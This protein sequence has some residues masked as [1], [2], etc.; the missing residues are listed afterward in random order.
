MYFFIFLG[1]YFSLNRVSPAVKISSFE[2]V[3]FSSFLPSNPVVC[4]LFPHFCF[5]DV[6]RCD[7]QSRR[8]GGGELYGGSAEA[9][10]DPDL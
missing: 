2:P 10:C 6:E 1:R 5:R 3:F 9:S 8:S 7:V 4:L